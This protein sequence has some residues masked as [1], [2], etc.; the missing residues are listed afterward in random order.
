MPRLNDIPGF[1]ET[2]RAEAFLI[3]ANGHAEIA[4]DPGCAAA[5]QEAAQHIFCP[6]LP[7]HAVGCSLYIGTCLRFLEQHRALAKTEIS[8]DLEARCAYLR[9]RA[10]SAHDLGLAQQCA[11]EARSLVA[12][13]VVRFGTPGKVKINGYNARPGNMVEMLS[14]SGVKCLAERA[15]PIHLNDPD[16]LAKATVLFDQAWKPRGGWGS[17]ISPMLDGDRSP[18]PDALIDAACKKIPFDEVRKQML[19]ETPV[20]P[21]P[22]AVPISPP[23]HAAAWS[24][25]LYPSSRQQTVIDPTTHRQL[26]RVSSGLARPLDYGPDGLPPTAVSS[27]PPAGRTQDEALAVQKFFLPDLP[28]TQRDCT[29]YIDDCLRFIRDRREFVDSWIGE[30]LEERCGH[31]KRFAADERHRNNAQDHAAEARSLIASLVIRF[32]GPVPG[33]KKR[34]DTRPGNVVEMVDDLRRSPFMKN[35]IGWI[36]WDDPKA[37]QTAMHIYDKGRKPQNGWGVPEDLP[38]PIDAIP[39]GPCPDALIH[40]ARNNSSFDAIRRDMVY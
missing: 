20:V 31:L 40:A 29:A 6:P 15:R 12:S 34:Y 9:D 27:R 17:P 2:N 16:G 26:P 8:P 19:A 11:E 32:G 13:L 30:A 33:R 4:Y 28:T 1:T 35:E 37:M 39:R 3:S 24:T 14:D 21:S 25:R 10:G 22:V 36:A 7:S 5:E 23:R 38:R 18:C